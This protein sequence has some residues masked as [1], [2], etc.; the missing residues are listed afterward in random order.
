MKGNGMVVLTTLNE[1]H[2]QL[3][4]IDLYLPK[5]AISIEEGDIVAF[6]GEKNEIR[7]SFYRFPDET[8]MMVQ[9]DVGHVVYVSQR[10]NINESE[11][12]TLYKAITS[13]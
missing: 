11:W 8:F 4:G 10:V 7:L 12:K 1:I 3:P 13:I 9:F 5:K 6:S 2:L